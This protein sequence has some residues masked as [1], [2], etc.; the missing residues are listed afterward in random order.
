MKLQNISF[1]LET[2]TDQ[3]GCCRR[4][5]KAWREKCIR[6]QHAFPKEFKPDWQE[7]EQVCG[8]K[9]YTGF[10]LFCRGLSSRSVISL[11]RNKRPYVKIALK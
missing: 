8:K 3:P 1:D 10:I 9:V 11:R 7:F 4:A 5:F 6:Q 2:R